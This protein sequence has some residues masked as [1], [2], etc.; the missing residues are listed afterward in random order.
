MTRCVEE[1][2]FKGPDAAADLLAFFSLP[3]VIGRFTAVMD[4]T[5]N[6][7]TGKRFFKAPKAGAVSSKGRT[8]DPISGRPVDINEPESATMGNPAYEFDFAG[9]WDDLTS[10]TAADECAACFVC[11][12]IFSHTRT[13]SYYTHYIQANP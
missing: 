7:R 2:C 8:R 13:Q 4:A 11:K 10:T 1:R 3:I 6:S 12:V 5:L 9:Q